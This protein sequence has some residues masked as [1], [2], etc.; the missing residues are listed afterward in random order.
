M[1][2]V[3]CS[4]K[5]ESNVERISNVINTKKRRSSLIS[6]GLDIKNATE[7]DDGDNGKGLRACT[8][9]LCEKLS[10]AKKINYN[11]LCDLIVEEIIA[12]NP[13]S[14]TF[15]EE[16]FKSED[17]N[18]KRRIY[19]ARN[20]L[21]ALNIIKK[22]NK[23]LVWQGLDNISVGNEVIL[24]NSYFNKA[25][26]DIM[27]KV[28]TLEEACL[29]FVGWSFVSEVCDYKKKFEESILDSNSI[30]THDQLLNRRIS[31]LHP[32]RSFSGELDAQNDK[33]GTDFKSL[34][35]DA[36]SVPFILIE[37]DALKSRLVFKLLLLLCLILETN[38]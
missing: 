30:V 36:I 19:D 33:H 4:R 20:I 27:E 25:R 10:K 34:K 16:K 15:T 29:R 31:S 6:S 5:K 3:L 13:R 7:I 12:E 8:L 32:Q 11:D 22:D 17:K 23:S 14:S 37:T 9:K 1:Y 21:F 18:I 38:G 35:P 26:K 2:M 28:I 24:L